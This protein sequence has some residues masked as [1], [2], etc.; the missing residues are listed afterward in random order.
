MPA[1][2]LARAFRAGQEGCTPNDLEP[3]V[4]HGYFPGKKQAK[5]SAIITPRTAQEEM[6]SAMPREASGGSPLSA[7]RIGYGEGCIFSSPRRWDRE[8]RPA[9]AWSSFPG[10]KSM[11]K[12]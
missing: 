9:V 8:T 4:S 12:S 1:D 11:V 7:F 6:I 2:F 10:C 5:R 3:P